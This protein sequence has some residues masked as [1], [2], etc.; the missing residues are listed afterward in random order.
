MAWSGD[1]VSLKKK[2]GLKT[3]WM[4]QKVSKHHTLH[5]NTMEG[6]EMIREGGGFEKNLLGVGGGG[7]HSYLLFFV[8]KRIK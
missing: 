3:I 2:Y 8:K 1:V 4:K 6:E 5:S 7:N